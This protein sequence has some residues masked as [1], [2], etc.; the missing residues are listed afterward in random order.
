VD[1]SSGRRRATPVRKNFVRSD[2]EDPPPLSELY[3]V[4]GRGGLVAIKFYLALLWR[5][6]SPPF[7]TSK[8][9]RAWAE[10]LGLEDPEV[11][12]A[13]RIA[14]ATKALQAAN[15]IRVS[16]EPGHEN[17][18]TLLDE[19]GDGREYRLPSTEYTK[20]PKGPRGDDRRHRNT[21]FKISSRLWTEGS[22]QSLKGPGLIMLLILL[23]EQGGE[24]Q[25]V[26]FATDIFPARYHISHKT[27]AIGTHELQDRVLLEVDREA[28]P[29][30]QGIVFARRRYRNVYAL[31]S[32]ALVDS[33]DPAL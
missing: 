22:I 1:S 7:Q 31:R 28:L 13:R 32:I 5:C 11:K 8:P 25:K 9:A 19:S 3:R 20:A 12:G 16:Y 27:R 21:Y 10:L 33:N 17:T 23:A 14:A 6:S 15:L 18:I 24:G 4:G 26:W 29:D 2:T 30:S